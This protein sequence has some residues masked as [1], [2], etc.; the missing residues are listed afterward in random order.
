MYEVV[1]GE[2]HGVVNEMV[3]EPG[4][5]NTAYEGTN[6]KKPGEE[7]YEVVPLW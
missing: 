1:T 3:M 6:V 4:T 2:D 7:T 5:G